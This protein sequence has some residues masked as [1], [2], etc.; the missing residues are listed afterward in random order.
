MECVE[1]DD[2]ESSSQTDLFHNAN[3]SPRPFFAEVTPH[4]I[5]SIPLYLSRTSGFLGYTVVTPLVAQKLGSIL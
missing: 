3:F 2:K 1:E 4:E 5:T